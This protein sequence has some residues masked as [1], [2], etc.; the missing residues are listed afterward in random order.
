MHNKTE[1]EWRLSRFGGK[2]P[3]PSESSSEGLSKSSSCY[4][5]EAQKN[6]SAL[7]FSGVFAEP[8]RLL[9]PISEAHLIYGRTSL[10][11]FMSLESLGTAR[12]VFYLKP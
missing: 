8:R 2:K 9:S 10:H 12:I 3:S 7:A 1:V 5:K 11:S 6:R 4:F